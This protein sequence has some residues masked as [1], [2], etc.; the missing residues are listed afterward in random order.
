MSPTLLK[1]RQA[2]AANFVL[3]G[4]ELGIWV[5]HI[6]EIRTRVGL[7]FHDLGMLLLLLGA[8]SFVAMTMCSRVIDQVGSRAVL[9]VAGTSV[10]ISVVGLAFASSAAQLAVAVAFYG[11]AN[12]IQDAGQNAHA[13]EVER[14]FGRPIMSAFHAYFSIGGLVAAVAGGALLGLGANIRV[15]FV[16]AGLL[17]LV[18]TAVCARHLLPRPAAD[19]RAGELPERGGW[20]PRILLIGSVAF[21]LLMAEG[22]AFDWSALQL[23]DVLQADKSAAAAGF[24]A[25]S[26]TMTAV[27]LLADRII[28]AV[29]PV[30]YMRAGTTLSIAGLTLAAAAPTIGGAILGWGLFGLG[31]AG[32]VPQVFSAAGAT[33][34]GASGSAVARVAAIGYVGH[35]AG[36]AV[37]GFLAPHVGLRWAMVVPILCCVYACGV[38]GVALRQHPIRDSPQAADDSGDLPRCRSSGTCVPKFRNPR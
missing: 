13:V 12:G 35:L 34:Q 2:T 14:A 26:V 36:P 18:T 30:A 20:N 17:G 19:S 24:G 23:R 32:C 28:A 1:A 15:V 9:I 29:G 25:F 6:P 3:F 10:S 7:T 4:F 21:A 22:V 31:I 11:F 27:R 8:C 16:G 33:S 5:V 37:I 38:A